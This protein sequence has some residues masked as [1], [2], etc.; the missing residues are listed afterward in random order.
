MIR[1][2]AIAAVAFVPGAILAYVLYRLLEMRRTRRE[3]EQAVKRLMEEQPLDT[4]PKPTESL[5]DV[6]RR[7]AGLT[8]QEML[9]R[10]AEWIRTIQST[11]GVE[12][13][14]HK[15]L[16]K[17]ASLG[18]PESFIAGASV[19]NIPMSSLSVNWQ[20]LEA[21]LG[22]R[23]PDEIYIIS[24]DDFD[25]FRADLKLHREMEHSR[26]IEAKEVDGL[27]TVRLA[28]I[29][30]HIASDIFRMVKEFWGYPGPGGWHR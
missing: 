5:A 6:L 27:V 28:G 9:A 3:A 13:A 20:T 12:Q 21:A 23:K 24:P 25:K 18:I 29:T 7:E 1:I 26:T 19:G 16:D 14:R 17:I 4:L 11:Y 2:F 8:E 15:E 10:K 30:Y 22:E